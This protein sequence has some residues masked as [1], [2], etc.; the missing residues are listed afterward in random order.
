MRVVHVVE[1]DLARGRC[2]DIGI[3]RVAAP[4][5]TQGR[6][7][8]ER[9]GVEI[10]QAEMLRQA[11]GERALARRRRPVDGDDQA[12]SSRSAAPSPFIRAGKPGKLVAMVAPSSIRTGFCAAIPR[13]RKA[14][15]MRWSRRVAIVPPP[16]GSPFPATA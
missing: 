9:S 4:Q 16:A 5:G 15:A 10:S 12:R 7:A 3:A 2:R 6:G 1:P 14:M 13:T 8:V 11:L